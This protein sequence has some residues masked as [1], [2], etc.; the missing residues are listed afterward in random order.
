MHQPQLYADHTALGLGGLCSHLSNAALEWQ[1]ETPDRKQESMV[2]CPLE[3]PVMLCPYYQ[4]KQRQTV[5]PTLTAAH[6]TS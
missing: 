3:G 2:A 5:L 6:S 4:R 1:T